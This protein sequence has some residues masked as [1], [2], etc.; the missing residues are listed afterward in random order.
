MSKKRREKKLVARIKQQAQKRGKRSKEP[1][2]PLQ[3]FPALGGSTF[4]DL[5]PPEGFRPITA[6]QAMIMFAEPFQKYLQS[7]EIDDMNVVMNLT[8]QIWNYTLPKVLH[9]PPKED[10]IEEIAE[11]LKIDEIDAANLFE[12][13]VERKAYLFPPEIQPDDVRTLFMR[14]EA[15][16]QIEQFDEAQL[17]MSETPIPASQN[18]QKMLADLQR[19]DQAMADDEEYD[20]WEDLYFTVEKAC[21]TQFYDW[22]A[23]KGVSDQY[24]QIFPFCVEM[25]FNFVYRYNAIEILQI[26]EFD[27]EEFFLD[28]LP[29]KVLVP[30]NEYAYWPPALRL[31]YRFLAE[32]GYL[33]D[34]QPLTSLFDEIE[35]EFIDMLQKQF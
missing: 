7:G 5:E 14:K 31:F 18:D 27:L 15:D 10:I 19:L 30:P 22:L 21:S 33:S 2:S 6:T 20:E 4:A 24:C 16:Y 34:P 28:H 26:S 9:K 29:R 11:T 35:P 13:M 12:G 32:K 25:F 23:A 17:E 8:T 3:F 1:L